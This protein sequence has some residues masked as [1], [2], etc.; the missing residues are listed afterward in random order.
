MPHYICDKWSPVLTRCKGLG[1]V[2]GLQSHLEVG[3]HTRTSWHRVDDG[4]HI[5]GGQSTR[6]QCLAAH[7][8][9]LLSR[10][11][12]R[13]ARCP[14]AAKHGN[15]ASG[16][17]EHWQGATLGSHCDQTSTISRGCCLKTLRG[18]SNRNLELLT[19]ICIPA[20]AGSLEAE[21]ESERPTPKPQ[22][23]LNILN[24]L[25][26]GGPAETGCRRGRTYPVC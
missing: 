21:C 24:A 5:A 14:E 16:G 13:L 23:R 9:A 11:E 25:E 2:R 12:G 1:A 4:R 15:A 19:C 3:G 22:A 7:V 17:H 8:N 10:K 6:R 18:L 20:S 26:A